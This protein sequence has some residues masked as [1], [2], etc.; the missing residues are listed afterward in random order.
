MTIK[1]KVLKPFMFNGKMLQ[2]GEEAE[3]NEDRAVRHM[4]VGD[5]EKNAKAIEQYKNKMINKAQA[6][7]KQMN[8][9]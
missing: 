1:A 8:K 9:F 2:T 5:V 6:T 7:I 3:M 4:H